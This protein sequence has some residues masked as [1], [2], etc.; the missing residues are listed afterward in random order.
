VVA[1]IKRLRPEWVR[2]AD[3]AVLRLEEKRLVEVQGAHVDAD[4]APSEAIVDAAN[5]VDVIALEDEDGLG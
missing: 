5:V 1:I 4:I 2:D 3:R